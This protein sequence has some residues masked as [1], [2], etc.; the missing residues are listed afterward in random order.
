MPRKSAPLGNMRRSVINHVIIDPTWEKGSLQLFPAPEAHTR[1]LVT[2]ISSKSYDFLHWVSWYFF[3]EYPISGLIRSKQWFIR[4]STNQLIEVKTFKLVP[5]VRYVRAPTNLDLAI[6]S[7][8]RIRCCRY[9]GALKL[10]GCW[11]F[12]IQEQPQLTLW[13]SFLPQGWHLQGWPT[14][15]LNAVSE[16]KIEMMIFWVTT[17]VSMC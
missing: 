3:L 17:H 7:V 6:I 8:I 16:Q 14:K 4:W 11:L 15:L 1:H 10:F 5:L 9:S 2:W 12:L 13:S